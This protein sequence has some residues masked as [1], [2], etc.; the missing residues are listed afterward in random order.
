MRKPKVSEGPWYRC[1]DIWKAE[2]IEGGVIFIG[3]Q[4]IY[5][6]PVDHYRIY[7]NGK[8][9]NRTTYF[10]ESAAHTV[11]RYAGDMVHWSCQPTAADL[12]LLTKEDVREWK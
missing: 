2:G 11:A 10:G 12:Y 1:S 9:I 3:Q 4:E 7:M 5:G 8:P 6:E